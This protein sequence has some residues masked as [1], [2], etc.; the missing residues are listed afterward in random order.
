M[1]ARL[2][3]RRCGSSWK[4]PP[5]SLNTLFLGKLI[6][7]HILVLQTKQ[8][9]R[10]NPDTIFKFTA[11]KTH[12]RVSYE[13]W[14][15]NMNNSRTPVASSLGMIFFFIF[16]KLDGYIN[17]FLT[18]LSRPP[19]WTLPIEIVARL[20]FGKSLVVFWFYFSFPKWRLRSQINISVTQ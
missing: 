3:C 9:W 15:R 19:A 11:L 14:L 4:F 12:D 7:S 5:G 16:P 6:I 8:T 10:R 18:P 20:H 13:C 17:G 1:R 2:P